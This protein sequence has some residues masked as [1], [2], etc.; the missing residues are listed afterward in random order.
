MCPLPLIPALGALRGGRGMAQMSEQNAAADA[1]P[2]PTPGSEASIDYTHVCIMV[3]HDDDVVLDPRLFASRP[4]NAKS[5]W[6]GQQSDMAI[7]ESMLAQFPQLRATYARTNEDLLATDAKVVLVLSYLT[8]VSYGWYAQFFQTLKTLEARGVAVYP[9]ADF[10]EF[11]SSKA[12]YMQLLQEQGRRVCPT[13]II[14]RSECV[15][16]GGEEEAQVSPDPIPG[17]CPWLGPRRG[18]Q[19][20]PSP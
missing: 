16:G 5:K 12:S 2:S 19:P 4:R 9:S 6:E 15:G 20:Q 8:Q 10:K 11:I 17:P 1:L 7:A 14:H 13:Q 18:L 3:G